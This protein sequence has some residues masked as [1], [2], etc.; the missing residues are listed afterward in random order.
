MK[1][2]S[3]LFS[4][5]FLFLTSFGSVV[6]AVRN[7]DWETNSTWNI[8]QQP[9]S[10]D[11]VVIPNGLTVSISTNLDISNINIT[12]DN[13]GILNFDKSGDKLTLSSTSVIHVYTSGIIKASGNP[14]NI[15]NIGGNKVFSGDEP[16]ITGPMF[17]SSTTTGFDPYTVLPVRLISFTLSHQKADVL[18]QWSTSTEENASHFEVEKSTD[19]NQWNTISQVNAAGHSGTVMNYSFIDRNSTAPLSY[20]RL[21][22]VDINGQF[23]YSSVKSIKSEVSNEILNITS[24]GQGKVALKF[25]SAVS[26]KVS[27]RIISY[28][29]Q[30]MSEQIVNNPLG[31]I[32]LNFPNKGNYIVSVS[33]GNSVNTAKQ[34]IL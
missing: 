30:I 23:V 2:I 10:G 20:Y 31:Q 5:L 18:I 6:T 17:A 25:A 13:Y 29:G 11:V 26:G 27:V 16:N 7:G 28:N 3:L 8:N 21:K 15:I 24:L 4:T 1:K 33:N 22:E 19:G 9:A 32:M 34:I 14:S 12:V